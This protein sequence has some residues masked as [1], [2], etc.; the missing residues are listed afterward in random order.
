MKLHIPRQ[1]D[2]E[3]QKEKSLIDHL[4]L[5]A[6]IVGPLATIPQAITVWSGNIEGVSTLTWV[7][8]LGVSLVLFVYSLL[9]KLKS[10]LI[11]ETVWIVME[12]IILVGIFWNS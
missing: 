1:L 8:F 2:K 11:A 12:I 9:Y 7:L 6:G 5:I 10:L 4:A 3:L